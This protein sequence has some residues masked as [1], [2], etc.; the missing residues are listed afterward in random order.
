MDSTA[1]RGRALGIVAIVAGVILLVVTAVV[2]ML[3]FTFLTLTFVAVVV[4]ACAVAMGG[5]SNGHDRAVSAGTATSTD[6]TPSG[7]APR[8][9]A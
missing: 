6:P 1:K 2:G 4:G 3:T 5:R 9:P 7:T 8:P